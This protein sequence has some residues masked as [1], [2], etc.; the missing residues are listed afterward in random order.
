VG[1][2]RS[3]YEHRGGLIA[4]R[5]SERAIVFRAIHIHREL[6]GRCHDVTRTSGVA[7]AQS[8]IRH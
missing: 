2:V 6:H 4:S 3:R 5:H 7:G 8:S 1:H